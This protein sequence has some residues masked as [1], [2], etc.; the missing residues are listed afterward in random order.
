MK[1]G[2]QISIGT[3]RFQ[4]LRADRYTQKYMQRKPESFPEA[5]VGN[6]LL[7]L[8]NSKT[9]S[10]KMFMLKKVNWQRNQQKSLWC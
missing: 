10:T 4:I 6:V 5:Q 2:A 1:I 3:W 9:N 8:K 7:K